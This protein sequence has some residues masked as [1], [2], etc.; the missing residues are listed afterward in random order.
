MFNKLEQA[1]DDQNRQLISR[2]VHTCAKLNL[3]TANRLSHDPDFIK[4]TNSLFN[5]LPECVAQVNLGNVILL[6]SGATGETTKPWTIEDID[7]NLKLKQRT[8]QFVARK[9]R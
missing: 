5:E 4:L 3:A 1:I 7:A 9:R 6:R 8:S 2:F